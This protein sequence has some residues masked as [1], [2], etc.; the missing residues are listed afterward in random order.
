MLHVVCDKDIDRRAWSRLVAESQTGTWFQ[1]PEAYDFFASLPELF[2]VFA[3]GLEAY[4]QPLPERRGGSNSFASAWGAHTADSTQYDL[5]ESNARENRK[6]PTEAESAMWDLL[7]SNNIGLHFRRQH[8]ILDYIVDFI[9]IEKGLVIELDGRYHTNPEQKEYD[10]NRTAHL[11]QLGYTELRFTNEELLCAPEQ[12]IA[13]IKATATSLP[14]LKGRVGERLSSLRAICVGYVTKEKNALK[15]FFTRRAIIIG[16]PC[17]ADDC[18]PEE[19]E[20]LMNAVREW[21]N[22]NPSLKGRTSRRH[23]LP[24]R[25]GQEVGFQPIYIETRNFNDYSQWREAFETAGF[26]YQPHLN[27]HVDTSSPDIVETNLGKSRKRDIRTTVREGVTIVELTN[28]RVKELGNERVSELVSEFY[29]IL[30]R[31][32]RT[33]VKTP[34]FPLS[35]FQALAKHPDGRL[36]LTEYQGRIIGGT[37]CVAFQKSPMSNLQSTNTTPAGVV[38]EWFA[39]G[40]DGVYPH[41]FPS[42]YATYAGIRYAAEHGYTRFDMMGAGK[43]GEAYGVRDFKAKF[44]GKEVE[45]GRYMCVLRPMLFKIGTIGV[46]ILKHLKF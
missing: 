44:G 45:H 2:D 9:C 28:E 39:C 10:D 43:P 29:A 1:S 26:A 33:K 30:Q 34:L 12:V 41:I 19:A 13:K 8:V 16:G 35:F 21:P 37:V 15:Q 23:T 46:R 22:L 38:Y 4:P 24:F 14:S 40:E 32:Y 6:N 31:L 7:K 17:L 27:F 3:V 25:E 5:L 42:C 11:E 36:L 18:T 20:T